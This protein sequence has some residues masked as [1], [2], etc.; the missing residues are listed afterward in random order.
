MRKSG[1]TANNA[2]EAV[3]IF[4]DSIHG[5]ITDY[6]MPIMNGIQATQII[7]EKERALAKKNPLYIIGLT[8]CIPNANQ[9]SVFMRQ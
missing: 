4:D 6:Q 8:A 3:E 9:F 7:R 2:Q 5:V 1:I